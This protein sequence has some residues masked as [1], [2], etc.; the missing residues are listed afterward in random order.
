MRTYFIPVLSLLVLSLLGFLPYTAIKEPD[1]VRLFQEKDYDCK[2]DSLNR[3]YGTN[4]AFQPSFLLPSLIALSYFPELKNTAIRFEFRKIKTTM[5]TRPDPDFLVSRNRHYTIYI[6]ND[7][8]TEG[9][10]AKNAPFNAQIGLIGHE[11]SHIIDYEQK[12][13]SEI[14]GT[15][16]RYNKL[17][18]K[19]YYEQSIDQLTITRGLGWQLY[20]WM[21][22]V[23]L[24]SNASPAYK[25]FKKEIYLEPAEIEQYISTS[26][27]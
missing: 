18:Y 5:Q 11:L 2:V 24:D 27:K 23:L 20:D 4:K 17:V 8:K 15:G 26:A 13:K 3:L 6:N 7:Q 9:V 21:N 1:I 22:Y 10:L 14:L 12:T 25:A 16:A 19:Q